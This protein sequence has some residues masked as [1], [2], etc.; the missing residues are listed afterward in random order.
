MLARNTPGLGLFPFQ[1]GFD[2]SDGGQLVLMLGDVVPDVLVRSEWG[3]T[4][5]NFK[6][7][8]MNIT[9]VSDHVEVVWEILDGLGQRED[10]SSLGGLNGSIYG[11]PSNLVLASSIS[12][13]R[14]RSY[15][16]VET[17]PIC[18]NS[19]G[20]CNPVGAAQI[21]TLSLFQRQRQT[22]VPS[23]H[24]S[25]VPEAVRSR[26]FTCSMPRGGLTLIHIVFPIP[27]GVVAL[28]AVP[29]FTPPEVGSGRRVD[30]VR[31]DD[32][33]VSPPFF[34]QLFANGMSTLFVPTFFHS[35]VVLSFAR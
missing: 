15:Y 4:L 8:V 9:T 2:P 25:G 31:L 27:S 10:F 14:S 29:L 26:V 33:Q 20:V 30:S 28:R 6:D 24:G 17:T 18:S 23:G 1:V 11:S 5:L 22:S 19:D 35:P 7:S 16:S 32:V 21:V 3:R 34:I 13:R 12:P